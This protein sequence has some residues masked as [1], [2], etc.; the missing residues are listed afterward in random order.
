MEIMPRASTTVKSS[1][2]KLYPY[3]GGDEFAPHDVRV[4]IKEVK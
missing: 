2:Y 4:W 1:G 3:F